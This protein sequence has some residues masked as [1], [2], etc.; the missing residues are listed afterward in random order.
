MEQVKEYDQLTPEEIT[1]RKEEMIRYFKGEMEFLTA[2][3]EYQQVVTELEELRARH[4]RAQ[5]M[6]ANA[7]APEPEA[8]GPQVPVNAQTEGKIAPSHERKLKNVK[9]TV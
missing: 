1:R 8:D 4:V 2:Q 7:L 3:K 9:Q 6:I 5:I